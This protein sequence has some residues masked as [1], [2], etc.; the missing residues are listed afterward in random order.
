MGLEAEGVTQLL[1][2]PKIFNLSNT[3]TYIEYPESDKKTR[4]FI[5]Y[6]SNE[7]N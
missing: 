2:S 3:R 6:F 1:S 5:A 7:P 4:G